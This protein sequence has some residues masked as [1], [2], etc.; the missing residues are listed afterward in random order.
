[1]KKTF[2]I[3]EKKYAV[4][5]PTREAMSK[6]RAIHA[7]VL[8][9]ALANKAPMR[10][11]LFNHM[12]EQGLWNDTKDRQYQDLLQALDD[13]ELKLARGGIKLKE[14]RA[15]AIEMRQNR[16]KLRILLT[17]QT[18][19][20]AFTM[21]GMAE[22]ARFDALASMCILDD[23]TGKPVYSSPEDYEINKSDDVAYEGATLFAQI[24]YDY[25]ENAEKALPENQFLIQ[26][27]FSDDN[28]RLIN[29]EGH[30]IDVDGK[31]INEQGQ[32]IDEKG[33]VID[34]SGHLLDDEGNYVVDFKPFLDDDGKPVGEEEKE[35]PAPAKNKKKVSRKK[36]TK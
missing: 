4:I 20:D 16:M 23:E 27:K 29:E 32:Y 2:E 17:D 6:A 21:E 9:E 3:N 7:R 25:D 10:P 24:Y 22:N 36:T 8:G 18:R 1:M 28:G 26:W 31:L 14:A 5:Q 11:A 15:I 35:E 33:Q 13:G 12:R 34:E 19:L 30:L